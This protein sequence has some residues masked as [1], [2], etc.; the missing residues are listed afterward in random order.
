MLLFIWRYDFGRSI[1]DPTASAEWATPL[2]TLAERN[3]NGYAVPDRDLVLALTPKKVDVLVAPLRTV[4]QA[5][6]HHGKKPKY[7][8]VV[9]ITANDINQAQRSC[10][11]ALDHTTKRW[12]L[13]EVV[14]NNG[15]P[16]ELYYL[17][18]TR[19]SVARDALLTEIRQCGNGCIAGAISRVGDALAIEASEQHAQK[20]Q[21]QTKALRNGAL[22]TASLIARNRTCRRW[23]GRGRP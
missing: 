10:E 18:R 22:R 5:H 8:A 14:T 6:R 17:V 2:A 3:G 12:K 15:K 13:D 20:K 23:S 19:K 11:K 21:D 4:A 7:N 16:S 9:T 1:L